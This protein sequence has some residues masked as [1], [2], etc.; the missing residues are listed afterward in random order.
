LIEPETR[1]PGF[2]W[3]KDLYS[4][5]G[6]RLVGLVQTRARRLLSVGTTTG[7]DEAALASRGMDVTTVPLDAVFASVLAQRGFKVHE[8]P[9]PS[10]MAKLE[11]ADFDAILIADVLHLLPSPTDWLR[12][13]SKVLA[14]NG[15]IVGSVCNTSSWLWPL[16][17][18]RHGRRCW[19][20]PGFATFGAHPMG[21]ARLASLC[22]A[23]RLELVE[24]IAVTEG[25]PS[26][27]R[28]PSGWVSR[29][30]APQLLFRM[31]RV[32]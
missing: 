27:A 32:R 31:R 11:G 19:I 30:L 24:T 14:L 3:S 22:R 4:P 23:S 15:E 25:A 10:A 21:A 7:Q 16:K 1:A 20:R 26:L 28:V 6:E 18:W 9:L 13:A 17:D 8:G 29:K 5:L 12:A 2:R